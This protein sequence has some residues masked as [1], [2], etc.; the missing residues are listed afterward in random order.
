M[1]YV[2]SNY[3][4]LQFAANCK[5]AFISRQRMAAN[6]LA[7]PL[8]AE[9]FTLGKSRP[10]NARRHSESP[11]R[12]CT[13]C[14]GFAPAAPLRAWTHVFCPQS[15][16][17]A[18]QVSES[19]WGLTLSRPLPVLPRGKDNLSSYRLVGSLPQQQPDGPQPHPRAPIGLATYRPFGDRAF[20]LLSPM[21]D[22]PQFRDSVNFTEFSR[23][24]PPP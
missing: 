14:E 3:R 6:R 11:R 12:A 15:S 19:I 21:G 17:T 7:H 18:L 24:Y 20:Q 13:H 9:L 8:F 23:G 16:L 22:Y 10:A 4:G 1:V 2:S 5:L